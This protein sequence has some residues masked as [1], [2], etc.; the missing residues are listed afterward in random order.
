MKLLKHEHVVNL[1]EVLASKNNIFLVLEL[2]TGGELFD[3][4]GMWIRARRSNM[5]LFLRSSFELVCLTLISWCAVQAGRL[6]ENE[7][8]RYF[9]ELIAGKPLGGLPFF[10][11]Q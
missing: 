4:I 1:I 11:A 3:K 9:Q 7:A 6:P 5:G 10:G 2:V 8:R